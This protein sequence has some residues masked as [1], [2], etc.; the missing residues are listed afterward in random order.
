MFDL[1]IFN[2]VDFIVSWRRLWLKVMHAA[3]KSKL[4]GT[5]NNKNYLKESREIA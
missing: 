5:K 2:F 4:V 1:F 3:S